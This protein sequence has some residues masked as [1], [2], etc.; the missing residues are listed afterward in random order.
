MLHTK[1]ILFEKY[2]KVKNRLKIFQILKQ[3]FII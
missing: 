3:T 2:L 1:L